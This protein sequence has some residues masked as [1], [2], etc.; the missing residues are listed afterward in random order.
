M[1]RVLLYEVPSY[2]SEVC[3]GMTEQ[4]TRKREHRQD[5]IIPAAKKA[6]KDDSAPKRNREALSAAKPWGTGQ[7]KKVSTL[8]EKLELRVKE[9]QDLLEKCGQTPLDAQM[10][11][12]LVD[13]LALSRASGSAQLAAIEV[14]LTDEW[15]GSPAEVINTARSALDSLIAATQTVSGVKTCLEKAASM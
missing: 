9:A 11:P 2:T 1:Q 13:Q 10:P 12:L 14:A 3:N 8:A 15:Q 5:T 6:R 4:E 7:K